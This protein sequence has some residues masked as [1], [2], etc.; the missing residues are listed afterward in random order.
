MVPVNYLRVDRILVRNGQA[1]GAQVRDLAQGSQ[2]EIKARSVVVAAGPWTE[3]LISGT[4]GRAP[5]AITAGQALAVNIRVD[6]VLSSVAIGARSRT[7][8]DSDPVGGGKRYLFAAPQPGSTL[9]GTWYA[10]AGETPAGESRVSPGQGSTSLLEEFN[11]ACPGLELRAADLAGCQWGWLR[12]K[13]NTERGRSLAL[14]ERPRILDHATTN[15]VGHLFSVEPVKYTTAR[16]VA[17]R[18]VD[19]VFRDLG[20]PAPPCRTAEVPLTQAGTDAEVT[21]FDV[22]RAVHE[23]MAVKLG[24]IVFRRSNMGNSL[25]I[26]RGAVTQIARLAGAELG[27]DTMRQGAEVDEVMNKTQ[28]PVAMGEPVG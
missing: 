23:E 5:G 11:Q 24:D 3:S 21:A 1:T 28:H 22:R 25:R 10:P 18:L 27:W 7:R 4:L 12:L 15:G 17:E 19:L 9:L 16:S 20:R 26:D 6:R 2:F 13:G 8:R 14:A